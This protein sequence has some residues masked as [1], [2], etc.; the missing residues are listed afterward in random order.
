MI[1]NSAEHTEP[2]YIIFEDYLKVFDSEIPAARL[3]ALKDE[4]TVEN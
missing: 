2:F 4:G 3:N 1:E